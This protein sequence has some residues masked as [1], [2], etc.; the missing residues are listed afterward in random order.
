MKSLNT[1]IKHNELNKAG[2]GD[3]VVVIVN[4]ENYTERVEV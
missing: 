4:K 1:K 3:K 2:N